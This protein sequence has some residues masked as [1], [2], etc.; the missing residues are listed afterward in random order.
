MTTE[1]GSRADRL[2]PV[3]LMITAGVAVGLLSYVVGIP[4]IFARPAAALVAAV[5]W[6]AFWLRSRRQPR[7]G[8]RTNGGRS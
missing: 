7:N 2:H 6:L 4:S 1:D 8:A 3:H 5:V